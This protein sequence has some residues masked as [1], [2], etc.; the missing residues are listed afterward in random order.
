MTKK[1][2][3]EFLD[4][5][6]CYCGRPADA[7][8]LLHDELQYLKEWSDH[9]F[10]STS[11]TWPPSAEE[12]AWNEERAAR[13]LAICSD[14]RAIWFLKYMLNQWDLIEH[15]SNIAYPWLTDKGKALLAALNADRIMDED[16]NPDYGACDMDKRNTE[17]FSDSEDGI[18]EI[19]I[20]RLVGH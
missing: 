8:A 19:G 10:A 13:Q 15:G 9:V 16:G 5:W 12:S 6:L 7:I 4:D 11:L 17:E 14:E 1:K 18:I 20:N 2:L 3:Y